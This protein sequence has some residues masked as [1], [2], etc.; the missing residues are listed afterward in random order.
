MTAGVFFAKYWKEIVVGIVIVVMLSAMGIMSWQIESKNDK[1]V[2]LQTSLTTL[3]SSLEALKQSQTS[4]ENLMKSQADILLAIQ[5]K[6]TTAEKVF[7]EKIIDNS[8]IIEKWMEKPDDEGLTQQFYDARNA[9][10]GDMF[11]SWED[12]E[13]EK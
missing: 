9:S 11:S 13:V 6:E 7:T 4:M 3:T 2:A 5:G 8:R 10:W 1:I 12:P